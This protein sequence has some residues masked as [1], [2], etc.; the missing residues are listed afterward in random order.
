MLRRIIKCILFA[1]AGAL[2]TIATAIIPPLFTVLDP[3][4]AQ[5][6]PPGTPWPVPMPKDAAPP[7]N[8]I[9]AASPF[10]EQR[11]YIAWRPRDAVPTIHQWFATE[12]RAGWPLRA[13]R[14]R[15]ARERAYIQTAGGQL[16]TT[17]RAVHLVESTFIRGIPVPDFITDRITTLNDTIP[18]QPLLP[19]FLI[20]TALYTLILFAL[21][22]SPARLRQWRRKR[23]HACLR[24]GYDIQA[25]PRCPECGTTTATPVTT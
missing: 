23:R 1:L 12:Y 5:L 14:A 22:T 13:L 21:V 8:V 25:L 18:L 2:L 9:T 15:D 10:A 24:C 20:N 6:P 4:S 3:V 7:S 17:G 11:D 16:R 19:G